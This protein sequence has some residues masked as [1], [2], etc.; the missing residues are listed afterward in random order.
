[1]VSSLR[2][3]AFLSNLE[4]EF[5]AIVSI[6]A[7]SARDLVAKLLVVDPKER[8]TV[9]QALDHPFMKVRLWNS[10]HCFACRELVLSPLA[11]LCSKHQNED[12]IKRVKEKQDRYQRRRLETGPTQT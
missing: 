12:V 1:M 2:P 9:E 7:T 5:S 8:Y 3:C 10:P 4:K 11:Y 6:V